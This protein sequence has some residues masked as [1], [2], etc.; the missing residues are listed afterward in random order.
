MASRLRRTLLAA[1]VTATVVVPVSAAARPSAVPAPRPAA[2]GPLSAA[3]LP[4]LEQRFVV[5]RDNIRAAARAADEHGDRTRA[6]A[7][8][9]MAAA[10]RQFLTFDGRDGGR[11]AEVFGDLARADRIAVLVPG[12]DTNLDTY[13]RFRA[14]AVALHDAVRKAG[15]P[16]TAVVAWLGYA[17]P[18]T[19]STD[20]LTTGRADGAAVQLRAF[21]GE[22][23]AA[24]PHAGLSLLCHSYGSVVCARAANRLAVADIALYG[25]PGT[26]F[27]TARELRS[28]ATV[29]AGRG[30]GDWIADVPH[31]RLELLG[32]DVGF[33]TDPVAAAFGA[34][35]FDAG[36]CGHSDYLKPG[37][38]A[39]E[40]L[41]LIAAGRTGE[42][43]RA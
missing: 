39:L 5:N 27:G 7:L 41:A 28:R 42:V 4:R 38:T 33:G 26:G 15:G 35:V 6:A 24:R 21:T 22:L 31:V 19:V 18:G 32:S 16:R 12:S 10:G 11:S 37:T 14:G 1:L 25:S 3:E 9:E 23:R 43:T 20:V 36:D 13:A 29:W 30:G 40:N 8:R 2:V 17:T 34:R